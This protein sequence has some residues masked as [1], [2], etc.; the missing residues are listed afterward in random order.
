MLYF[1][2]TDGCDFLYVFVKINTVMFRDLLSRFINIQNYSCMPHDLN[3]V[4]PTYQA[5]SYYL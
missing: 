4:I 5:G 2:S 1:G 3:S